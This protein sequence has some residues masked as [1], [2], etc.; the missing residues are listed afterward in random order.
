MKL[1]ARGFV[2]TSAL[3]LGVFAGSLF[4]NDAAETSLSA[5]DL[6]GTWTGNFG[7]N[8]G[9][10]TIEITRVEGDAVYGTLE[11]EGALIRF[12]GYFNPKTRKFY[13]EETKILRLAAHMGEWSLGRNSA[14]VT[15][16]GRFFTG[17]GYDRWGQYS[18]S[19][20]NY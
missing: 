15:A 3:V 8:N 10:C 20:S 18:F 13:F 19:A 1:I 9:E 16:D 12:E 14:A 2:F 11:K 5:E 6:R 7:R 4:V 17:D